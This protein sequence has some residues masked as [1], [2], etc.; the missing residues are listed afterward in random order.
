MYRRV[1]LIIAD[2][3]GVGASPDACNFFNGGGTDEGCDTYGSLVRYDGF[4][5]PFL[6]ESG[7]GNIDGTCYGKADSPIA[8][9]GRMKEM[10]AGKDTVTGHWEICGVITDKPMPTYP[11]GFPEELMRSICDRFGRGWLCNKPYSGTEVIKD[12]GREHIET[13]N[14]IIYTSSDSVFQIAAHESVVP[15]EE[16]YDY[17]RTAREMLCGDNAVGRVIARPF[18][19]EYPNYVR[20]AN[21]HDYA[22]EPGC[23]TLCDLISSA[24]MDVIGIGKIGD[25]FAHR[26]I[27]EEIHTESNTDG[28][29]KTIEKLNEDFAGLCFVNLVDFDSKYGHRR[30]VKGY[31]DAV[32]ELDGALRKMASMLRSDDV[33]IVSADHGCDPGFKGTDHTREYVPVLVYGKNIDAVNIGTRSSFADLGKTI[34]E[35]LGVNA[36]AL[37][38]ESFL[39]MINKN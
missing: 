23:D 3:L 6:H 21:R 27:T 38:G 18:V 2:S 31:A 8:A 37:S 19:G 5:A 14:L 11:D 26:G 34:A 22:L 16:L 24:G 25:I 29:N 30:D 28:I 39:I 13:G 10:S 1:F 7:I 32:V 9:Y 36:E 35:M 20:T 33:L 12:Y 17:C 15:I 4:S